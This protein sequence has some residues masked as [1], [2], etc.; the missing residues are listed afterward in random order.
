VTDRR[1]HDPGNVLVIDAEPNGSVRVE[2]VHTGRW[3]FIAESRHVGSADDV[4]LLR[5]WLAAR[6]AKE[7]TGIWLSL[8]GT[9]SLT[10]FAELESVLQDAHELF[11]HVELWSRRT[12]LHVAPNEHDLS[13]LGLTGFAAQTLDDLRATLDPR[14]A[15]PLPSGAAGRDVCAAPIAESAQLSEPSTPRPEA[16]RPGPRGPRACAGRAR[17]AVPASRR[18]TMRL[19]RIRL[20]NVRGVVER[21]IELS[22]RGVTV[23]EG[24]NE[25]G[26]TTTAEAV[27]VLFE[28]KDSSRAHQVRDLFAVGT[29]AGP[30]VEVEFSTRQCRAIYVKQWGRGRT[31]QLT[32]TSPRS[33]RFSGDEAH[34]RARQL[35]DSDVDPALWRAL[36]IV[37]GESLTP[38]AWQHVPSLGQALDRAAAASEATSGSGCGE[39]EDLFARV[40]AEAARFFTVRTGQPTGEL[41]A[42]IATYERALADVV[43][44]RAQVRQAQSDVYDA[45]RYAQSLAVL[46]ERE[47]QLSDA[48]KQARDDAG[49]VTGLRKALERAEEDRLTATAD[50]AASEREWH[51]RLR[52]VVDVADRLE[53]VK[54]LRPRVEDCLA[55]EQAAVVQRD[56]VVEQLS[57]ART[58]R[59]GA[60]QLATATQRQVTEARQRRDLAAAG[61]RLAAAEQHR[62][63]LD[64]A[65]AE[66]GRCRVDDALL[67][68]IERT[69]SALS[70][71][72]QARDLAAPVLTVS[73]LGHHDVYVDGVR[74]GASSGA[75][76]EPNGAG[77]RRS[78]R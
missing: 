30:R 76:P 61:E 38:A 24:P 34:A 37:Q 18:S 75:G 25:I 32:L 62:T 42:A 46:G 17:P 23:V 19:H 21:S 29:D 11:A 13:R 56:T 69:S 10:E 51:Q 52:D 55:Q 60:R 72:Q 59:D 31:T 20:E 57:R 67:R 49:R 4:A 47:G 77:D 28:A 14:P 71:A 44:R 78:C 7:Q 27:D 33:Q 45:A 40:S 54:A 68:R 16:R 9:L 1:E 50:V 58:A 5:R 22:E 64:D 2:S 15:T 12:D 6:P 35:L 65:M 66:L 63:A 8:T 36:K 73:R 43:D 74:L 3:H 26:K 41:A 48:L 70:Q 39:P 53:T